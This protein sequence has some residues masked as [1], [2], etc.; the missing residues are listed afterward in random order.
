MRWWPI[1][2]AAAPLVCSVRQEREGPV[3]KT[4][5]QG[6]AGRV[7]TR[8]HTGFDH[9]ARLGRRM[10]GPPG[11]KDRRGLTRPLPD[12]SHGPVSQL[13]RRRSSKLEPQCDSVQPDQSVAN[14]LGQLRPRMPPAPP[15]VTVASEAAHSSGSQSR[16]SGSCVAS[17]WRLLASPRT[18]PSRSRRRPPPPPRRRHGVAGRH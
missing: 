15:S 14:R 11:I 8:K 12:P 3:P 17:R 16:F 4:Y 18:P 1:C 9:A 2:R 10:T 5:R 13:G 7:R 6:E